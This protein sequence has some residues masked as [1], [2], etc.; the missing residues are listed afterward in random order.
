MATAPPEASVSVASLDELREAAIAREPDRYLAATLAPAE[1]RYDLIALAA[2]AAEISRVPDLVREPLAGEI[3]L[4]W[5]RDALIGGSG[6]AAAGHPVAVAMRAAIARFAL[7]TEIVE[8]VIDAQADALHGERP[9]DERAM[10]KRLA[11]SEGGVFRLAARICAGDVADYDSSNREDDARTA[12]L[13]GLAY[14]LSRGLLRARTYDAARLLIPH[15]L[16]SD[17]ERDAVVDARVDAAVDTVSSMARSAHADVAVRMRQ[18]SRRRRL[19]FLPLAMV[20]P[21]LRALQ[22]ELGDS[23]AVPGD[24]LPIGRLLRIG[25]AHVSGRV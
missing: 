13:A 2:F 5:W 17:S 19:A 12:D 11:A 10:R 20:R 14:G 22:R 4:Q 6:D 7:P 3:R 1:L 25:W 24:A 21:N 16:L 15:S 18:M 9:I 8:R 23:A